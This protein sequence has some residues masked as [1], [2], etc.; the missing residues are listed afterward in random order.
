MIG[1]NAL[2]TTISANNPFGYDRYGYAFENLPA[3]GRFLDYG[4]GDGSFMH[5]CLEV[6]NID[7]IGVDANQELVDQNKFRLDLRPVSMPLPFE[8]SSFDCITMLDVLEHIADQEGVLAD[9][10][11]VLKPEGRFIITVPGKHCFSFLDMGNFK[12][13]F[14]RLHRIYIT[15][16]HSRQHYVSKYLAGDLVGDVERAK[17]WHQHFRRAELSA[18]LTGIGF[19]LVDLDGSGLFCR[20]MGVLVYFK[21]GFLVGES[22]QRADARRFQSCNLFCTALKGEPRRRP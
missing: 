11:R 16:A 1:S 18:L 13:L 9:L 10:R 22:L 2:K 21:L 20:P 6:K 8:D 3:Q 19:R 7:F 15:M 17:G 12:F 14:P 5:H 4:C